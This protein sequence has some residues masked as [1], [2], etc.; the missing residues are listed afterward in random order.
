MSIKIIFILPNIYECTNGVSTKYIKF[1]N[2]ISKIY[3]VVLFT[4]FIKND[5]LTEI[6]E[7]NILNKN[8]NIIKTNGLSIPFY[9]EIKIPIIN[10][11]KLKEEIKNGN[12]III[13]NGEFIWVYD[14]LINI[15]KKI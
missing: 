3:N 2:Y 7:L 13:F 5:N 9:K 14:L 12:E 8:L 10:E 15:K 11:K 4:T 6:N 1:I